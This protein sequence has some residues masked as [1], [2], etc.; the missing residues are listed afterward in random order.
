M[1]QKVSEWRYMRSRFDVARERLG[2]A[3]NEDGLHSK[4]YRQSIRRFFA[5]QRARS[6]LKRA[7]LVDEASALKA[8]A[9][10]WRKAGKQAERMLH[11]LGQI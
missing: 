2:L 9:L 1:T 3:W 10:F 7:G 6:I 4:V 11:D 8:E 5:V